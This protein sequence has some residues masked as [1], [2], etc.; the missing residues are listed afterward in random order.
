VRNLNGRTVA[1]LALGALVAVLTS[2]AARPPMIL[3]PESKP[4]FAT[5]YQQ[6]Q[7]IAAAANESTSVLLAADRCDLFGAPYLR[8]WLL[9]FSRMDSPVLLEPISTVAIRAYSASGSCYVGQPE[10]PY[11]LT[12]Q[13]ENAKVRAQIA[14]IFGGALQSIGAAMGAQ[15]QPTTI[16]TSGTTITGPHNTHYDVSGQ[17][18]TVNDQGEKLAARDEAIRAQTER[19]MDAVT[20]AHEMFAASLNAGLLRKQTVF[21]QS[22]VNGY[23]YVPFQPYDT[24][25][26]PSGRVAK[27][28]QWPRG[29]VTYK[30][31]FTLPGL[32]DSV[33]F[34]P[35]AGE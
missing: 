35:S 19:R 13:G 17:T 1:R 33:T 8:I 21:P 16:R 6:G 10:L 5:Y 3:V 25:Y 2:S 26:Y 20:S 9:Y 27:H 7:A 23:I 11:K 30:V 34:T 4:G 15:P 22:G 32:A 28:V 31:S 14:T 24:I 18:S 29:P 12:A